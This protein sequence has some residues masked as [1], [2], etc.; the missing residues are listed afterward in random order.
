MSIKYCKYCGKE[1]ESNNKLKLYCCTAC[2]NR[3]TKQRFKQNH[4]HHERD[5]NR[6]RRTTVEGYKYQ[7]LAKIKCKCKKLDLPFDLTIDDLDIPEYCPV[8]GIK[9]NFNH[10]HSGYFDDSPSVDR[11]IPELGYTKDNIK[12]IS[13]RANLL[14]NNATIEELKLIINYLQRIRGW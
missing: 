4:P 10:G 3:M 9:I 11:I 6:K 12:I 14:K 8:L 7:W 2:S 13:N 5:R 1:F